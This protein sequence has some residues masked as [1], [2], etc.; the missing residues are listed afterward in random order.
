MDGSPSDA[1][2]VL[3][4]HDDKMVS[5]LA[6]EAYH[7][8]KCTQGYR[9]FSR[10][11][12]VHCKR[13]LDASSTW[14]KHRFGWI[15]GPPDFIHCT[16]TVIV[17][18]ATHLPPRPRTVLVKLPPLFLVLEHL[19]CLLHGDEFLIRSRR[20]VLIRMP[21][22]QDRLI[23]RDNHDNMKCALFRRH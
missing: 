10:V 9:S 15:P 23:S 16:K 21:A 3:K 18:I 22:Y 13:F 1:T 4:E 17:R 2:Y 5:F 6:R 7:T 19:V 8:C 14:V 20:L 11:M 12:L